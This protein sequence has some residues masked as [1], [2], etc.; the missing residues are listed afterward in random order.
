MS[1][2][3]EVDQAMAQS[4]RMDFGRR[5]FGVAAAMFAE[6]DAGTVA[7]E[8]VSEAKLKR[9]LGEAYPFLRYRLDYFSKRVADLSTEQP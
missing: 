4:L 6:G 3:N 8:A 9:K 2:R 1:S 7:C 5:S